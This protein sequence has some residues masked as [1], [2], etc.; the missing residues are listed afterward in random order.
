M[1]G[2]KGRS[3][4]HN[5]KTLAELRLS[6]GV[7]PSRHLLKPAEPKDIQAEIA[8][9][10]AFRQRL[11]EAAAPAG[12][13]LLDEYAASVVSRVVLAGK[14]H[15]LAC[16]RHQRDRAR[17][18]TP[19]FPW[20]LDLD[21]VWRFLVFVRELKHYK[22]EWAGQEIVLEPWQVFGLGSIFGWVHV[23]TGLR[24]FRRSWYEVPRK[25]GKSLMAAI[26][27]LYITFFDGEGGSEGYCAATKKDQAKIVFGDCQQL[28]KSSILKVGIESFVR[29]LSDPVTMSKLE[30]LGA[31]SDSTD[32]LNPNLV[33]QDEFHA[34]KDRRMTAVLETATSARRQPH[35][36]RI[37][38]AGDDPVSPGG[39]EHNYACE[40]LEGVVSDETCLAFIAHADL[41]DDWADV[42]TWR[43]ANPNFSISVKSDDLRAKAEKAK[44]MPSATAEFQQKHLNLWVNTSAPCLSMDGWRKGQTTWT[45]EDMKG[46][47]CFVGFDLASRLD[48]FSLS[49]LFPPTQTRVQW[50]LLNFIWTPLETVK[51]RAHADRAPYDIWVQQ[52]WLLTSSG[53]END[54]NLMREV[55]KKH[56]DQFRILH[57][58]YD[59]WHAHDVIR[60]LKAIDGFPEDKIVA[61]GQTYRDLSAAEAT[62]Q[63]AVASGHIDARGCPVTAWAASNVVNV[64]DGKGN[65]QFSKR[66]SRGR[67]DP[68]KSA[69]I[70]MSLALRVPAAKPFQM[71]VLGATR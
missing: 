45:A 50:R 3:G 5:R 28:V 30:P 32:G 46:E 39:D 15:V 35:D 14:Y 27:A 41:E 48:L 51:E 55:L 68:I 52:K 23:E 67:I 9:W 12:W 4:G 7:V 10:D 47:P 59:P 19:E 22:G 20:R 18:G 33:I 71:I 44:N 63:A 69:T 65:I 34:Y 70:A 58:G 43:K 40:I 62:F 8:A 64:P 57:I 29:I 54:P 61:V 11:E 24:R 60:D 21:K 66:K 49:F 53:T 56:R 2:V 13:N 1:A 17:E 25:N 37:T 38:T 42:E 16:E 31:D 36:M 6:G 26:V